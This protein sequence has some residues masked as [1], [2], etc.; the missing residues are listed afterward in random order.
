LTG[1]EPGLSILNM[2]TSTSQTNT[3]TDSNEY[4]VSKYGRIAIL[5]GDNYAAFSTTCRTAIVVAGAW[6][7]V[8]GSE[9]RP[10]GAAGR[11]WDERNRK[12]IQLINSSVAPYLRT[13][14]NTHILAEDAAA[15]WTE[16]AREDRSTNRVHQ[17][18]LF[19]SFNRAVWNPQSESI[20]TFQ[21]RLQEIRAQLA[22]TERAISENDL[23]WRIITAIPDEQ[24]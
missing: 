6:A 5:N 2:T 24:D 11:T 20:R 3:L 9:P 12:A 13:Q 21:A 17:A 15:M 1:Y 4:Y 10:G 16:L 8:D 23:M 22:D 19:S 14:I 18:T 7:C